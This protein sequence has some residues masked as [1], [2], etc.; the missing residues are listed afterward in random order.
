MNR[1]A[2]ISPLLVA[3]TACGNEDSNGGSPGTG[4]AAGTGGSAGSGGA[5]SV[6]LIAQA[7][8][9]KCPGGAPPGTGVASGNELRKVTLS[10]DPDALCNDGS[11]AIM[12]VRA[13][14]SA[15]AAGSWV[16]HLQPGGAC[17]TWE[18]CRNRWCSFQSS[19]DAAKMS[20]TFAPDA[21]IASGI[22]AR[23]AANAF[24]AANQVYVYYCSSDSHRGRK[25]DLVFDDP[26]GIGPS[27]RLHFQGFRIIE[28]VNDALQKGVSSD[29]G[30]ESLPPLGAAKQI[31]FSGSSAGSSGQTGLLDWWSAQ[32]PNAKLA[33]M[34][35]SIT[36]PLPEDVADP[37][38]AAAYAEGQKQNYANVL[39]AAHDSFMDQ[40]C[41]A[42]HPGAD[43]H[44]C[45]LGSHV[46]LNHIT[47]PFFVRQDLR[48]PVQFGY[49][50]LTGASLGQFADA[51]HA[52]MQ[53]FATLP[54]SSEEKVTAAPGVHVSNCGQHIVML[55]SPWF[56]V[57]AQQNASVA[58]Q[59]GAPVT[60]HDGL[61][62]W[63]LGKP[64]VAIDTHPSTKSSCLATTG[65]Q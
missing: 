54:Q 31:L 30:K 19:Y 10:A 57:A 4:G 59:A 35:D 47:T 26:A 53:R 5:S 62:D 3:L 41:V 25:R 1:L 58:D 24:G 28:A 49:F 13:A 36:D 40:S 8:D 20:S 17:G 60:L 7:L 61:R 32:Y 55:N 64:S 50:G 37:T 21:T 23:N 27:F 65:E 56:G 15:A 48:D 46:R 42:A 43:A 16:I 14:S 9:G 11:P 63:V 38:I 2:F 22:F 18:E 45:G 39:V 51:V 29:D 34:L 44:L 33:G 12:Y 52:T 6:P